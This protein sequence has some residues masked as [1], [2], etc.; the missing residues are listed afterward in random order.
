MSEPSWKT[1][2]P[3]DTSSGP[4]PAPRKARHAQMGICGRPAFTSIILSL[5]ACQAPRGASGTQVHADLRFLLP[6]L[7][8]RT[9]GEQWGRMPPKS[10][11]LPPVSLPPTLCSGPR[12]VSCVS[13]FPSLL[14]CPHS[15]GL[16]CCYCFH[17]SRIAMQRW[18]AG[19]IFPLFL[20]CLLLLLSCSIISDSL[21]PHGLQHTRLPCPSP[22]PRLGSN[23]CPLSRWCHPTISSS[24]APFFSCPPSFPASGSFPM[25]RLFELGGQRIGGSASVLPMDIQGWFPL[26]L[27]GLISLQSKGLSR[28]FFVQQKVLLKKKLFPD[29]SMP[30]TSKSGSKNQ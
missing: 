4:S 24:V 2:G 29:Y 18:S 30:W 26:E 25:H 8:D 20:L 21:W 14:T 17:Q 19:W 16:C 11:L 3:S 22:S 15:E 5:A 1:R 6:Q 27:T 12:R 28:V 10:N 13:L 7:E 23:S 9:Q